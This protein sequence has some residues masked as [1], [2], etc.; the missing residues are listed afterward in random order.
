MYEIF[1]KLTI[2]TLELRDTDFEHFN[3]CWVL[4]FRSPDL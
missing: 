3:V 1:S 2:K 4:Y